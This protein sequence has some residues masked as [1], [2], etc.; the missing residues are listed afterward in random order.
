MNRV[1]FRSQ[2]EKLLHSK[3]KIAEKEKEIWRTAIIARVKVHSTL[4][5]AKQELNNIQYVNNLQRC[6]K[7]QDKETV[8]I[9]IP[10]NAGRDTAKKQG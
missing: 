2:T 4:I 6:S 5:Y 1:K 9:K 7:M 10:I 3:T 8:N